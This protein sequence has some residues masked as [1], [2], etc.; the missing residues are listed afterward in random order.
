ML[1]KLRKEDEL[2]WSVKFVDESPRPEKPDA[3]ELYETLNAAI[4][5]NVGE[6][7]KR[8][9]NVS[10]YNKMIDPYTEQQFQYIFECDVPPI[11]CIFNSETR[12]NESM[13]IASNYDIYLQ[14]SAEHVGVFGVKTYN[15]FE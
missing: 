5:L 12:T 4:G 8:K 9:K 1:Q 15:P 14:N 6:L 11:L 7:Y 3:I 13:K 2:K 10:D